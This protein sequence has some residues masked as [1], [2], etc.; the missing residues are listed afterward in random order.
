[1]PEPQVLPPT[2]LTV[3]S[4]H[5]R[6]VEVRADA[7]SLKREI[8][9][10]GRH[11]LIYLLGPALA[12]AVSFVLIP[13]YTYYIDRSDYGVMSLVDVVI[14]MGMM[15]LSRG[16]SDGLARHYYEETD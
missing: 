5:D 1:M 3:D 16:A 13:I 15:I 10:V 12:N 2:V 9:S 6:S 14:T 7:P 4:L 8:R 11:S